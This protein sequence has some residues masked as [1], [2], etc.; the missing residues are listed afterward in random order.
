MIDSDEFSNVT[1][2]ES[3]ATVITHLTQEES[4]KDRHPQHPVDAQIR[5][6]V[7]VVPTTTVSTGTYIR[8]N[9]VSSGSFQSPSTSHH[10][11]VP[12]APSVHSNAPGAFNVSVLNKLPHPVERLLREFLVVDGYK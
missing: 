4:N 8:T 9:L 3:A 7:D 5:H 6:P 10:C 1:Q 12:V 2:D 11:D